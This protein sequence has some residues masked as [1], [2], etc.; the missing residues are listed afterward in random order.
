MLGE[1]DEPPAPADS[2]A[3][4]APER[5]PA[6]AA[7][8]LA[9]LGVVF[10]DIGTSPLYTLKTCFDT[11][12]V[13]PTVENVLGIC[14][15][16]LYALIWV[17]CL[18]Y[19]TILLRVN[20]DG[21]GG[22]LALLALAE[23]PKI[24]GVELKASRLV[25]VAAVGA[26]ML[27]GDGFITPAIS[28]LSAVEGL[29]VATKSAHPFIVPISVGLLIGLFALQQS[30]TQRVGAL[31]GPVMLVWFVAIGVAGALAIAGHPEVV[32]VIDPRHAVGFLAHD[33]IRGFLMFGAV[34]LA[35][36]GAEALYADL[37]H[38]G[39]VP[40]T[41]GW[42]AIVLPA[43]V[44]NYVGQGAL[45]L[46]NPAAL[47]NPFYGLVNGW[48]LLP[49][50]ALA[51]AATIIASQAVISGVFTL[52]EQAI[53]LNL[54]PRF[55]VFH[56]SMHLR[57][58]VFVPF[59]NTTLGIGC[60]ALVLAFRGSDRL[61]AAYGL[62]V[63]GTMLATD[64]ALFVVATRVLKWRRGLA[65]LALVAFGSVDALFFVSGLPKFFEGA[66]VPIGVSALLVTIAITWLEG[67]RSLAQS[68]VEQQEPV[69]HFLSRH[70]SVSGVARSTI[71]F[72]T[73]DPSGIPFV[74]THHWL[75]TVIDRQY[76]ILLTLV[77]ANRPYV[78]PSRRV[79]IERVSPRF[80]RIA[81]RFGYM[82]RPRIVPV[83]EA[84]DK[85]DFDIDSDTT[86][87]VYADPVI[88]GKA[89]GHGFP[90]WRRRLFEILQRL[91]LSLADEMQIKA[92]RRVQLGLEVD[93]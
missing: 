49:M 86:L 38:F 65:L 1:L 53:A 14:S 9:A 75:H 70:R 55:R 68:L 10:G 22:I 67:R 2:G 23:P 16:L 50:V 71:V 7:L 21:E 61:A 60:V 17:V 52:S 30:G 83:I 46:G 76:I 57:G 40:I 19:V 37:S 85:L 64:V 73:G 3:K 91:S 51:T 82:E 42:Y 88:V 84:C 87:Y 25:L 47:A 43:L 13:Q 27:V 58:Q 24:F 20:H 93:L 78:N 66:W 34:V 35:V 90:K 80:A 63:A 81:A 36:T 31:F 39:R 69:E 15:L 6:R 33:G 26:A 92:N 72:L 41:F 54:C 44:L 29:D 89:D 56:T 45:V 62:S 5:K 74:S 32:W 28:V 4:P 79:M 12:K 11:A 77:P 59:V 48:L 8:T 18:K